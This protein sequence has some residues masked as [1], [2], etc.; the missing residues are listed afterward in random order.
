[1]TQTGSSFH[2]MVSQVAA[3]EGISVGDIK[4]KPLQKVGAIIGALKSG[5]IDA[6]IIVPHIAKPLANSGAAKIIGW[7]NDY[8]D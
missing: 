1:M 3:K 7:I 4:K 8:D 2:Y 5:Q 6:M